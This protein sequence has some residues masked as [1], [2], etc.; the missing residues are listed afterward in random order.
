MTERK[1]AAGRSGTT[2]RRPR[3][4]AGEG[5]RSRAEV[6]KEA[7]EKQAKALKLRTM[8]VGYAEIARQVGYASPGAAHDAVKR[9]LAAI[10]RENAKELRTSELEGLDVAERALA[11]RL[12]R[13]DLRAIDRMLRIKDMRAKLTG[14]YE[15]T[16][17]SGIEE[18]RAVLAGFMNAAIRDDEQDE[19]E[20]EGDDALSDEA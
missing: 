7:A 8:R 12:A 14:L 3:K 15:E 20:G 19:Q 11:Q 10:P 6:L 2:T 17:D 18:V 13:G 4:Q 9:A 5:R 16:T 1:A